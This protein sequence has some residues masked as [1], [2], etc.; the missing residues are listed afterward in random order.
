M[1]EAARRRLL[2]GA[3]LTR[4]FP[5]HSV[6]AR[7]PQA[8]IMLDALARLPPQATAVAVV[9][10]HWADLSVTHVAGDLG[11][12]AGSVNRHNTGATATLHAVLGEPLAGP[13]SA[14]GPGREQTKPRGEPRWMKP[15]CGSCW[16]AR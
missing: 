8:G 5:E 4:A 6:P 2:A 13:G 3:L 15:P 10:R 11:C 14:G 16:T 12:T 1:D 7:V 9:L